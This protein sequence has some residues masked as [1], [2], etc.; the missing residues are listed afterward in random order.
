MYIYEYPYIPTEDPILVLFVD[1]GL[2]VRLA[3][4]VLRRDLLLRR[5]LLVKL[6]AHLEQIVNCVIKGG[7]SFN[8]IKQD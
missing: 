2:A 6:A 1:L 8:S 7:A 4:E 5:R 3:G